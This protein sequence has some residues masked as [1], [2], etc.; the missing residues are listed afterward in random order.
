VVAERNKS[1]A[2]RIPIRIAG[3][4]SVLPGP[5][6]S[7]AEMAR[8]VDP[9]RDP[10]QVVARTGI[11]TR[12]FSVQGTEASELAGLALSG[13]LD[14]A[15]MEARRLRR[16]IFVDSVGGDALAPAT[17][18]L[19]AADLDLHGSCDCFDLNNTCTGFL[20]AFDL[21]ARSI[22]TGRGPVGIA[23]GEVGHR[24]ITPEDPRPFLVFGD[25][26]AAVVL[27]AARDGEGIVAA[28]LRND[29]T[30][31]RWVTLDHGSLTGKRETLRFHAPN[32]AIMS[33]AIQLV[34]LR[35]EEVLSEAGL[36]LDDV[37]WIL[38]H[39][40]NG[41]L[42]Q[43]ILEALGVDDDRVLR[44]VQDVGSV[45]TA[46]IPISL[47]RL[48]RSGR[49]EAG[50]RLLMLSVGAGLSSGAILLQVAT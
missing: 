29:G 47:D 27:D 5:K 32:A 49:L 12:H 35:A 37:Q 18:N 36:R 30:R 46:S 23:I 13:A 20:T 42:L 17:A 9:P 45:G 43:A 41:A 8:R 38:P 6:V 50:D 16:I 19:V 26:G 14:A 34:Q 1:R 31:E 25:A 44:V 39:Q 7:T 15:G 28:S 22:A 21:A 4:C 33:R 2:A 11:A 40:P 3:T 10:E 24:Y 48:R